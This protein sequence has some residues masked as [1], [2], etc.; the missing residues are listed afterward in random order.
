MVQATVGHHNPEAAGTPKGVEV[1]YDP[2]N[3]TNAQ[4]VEDYEEFG[5]DSAGIGGALSLAIAIAFG[6]LGVATL[7]G[8]AMWLDR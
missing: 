4:T 2:K 7:I 3:P 5:D 8:G 6:L 1:I